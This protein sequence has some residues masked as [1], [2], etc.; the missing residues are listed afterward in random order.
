MINKNSSKNT[1]KTINYTEQDLKSIQ[2]AK[3]LR[4]QLIIPR[5][6]TTQEDEETSSNNYKVFENKK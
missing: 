1:F 6:S 5:G 3:M 4:K 2:K